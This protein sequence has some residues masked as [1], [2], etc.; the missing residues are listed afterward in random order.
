MLSDPG[1]ASA[2][3]PIQGSDVVFPVDNPVDPRDELLSGLNHMAHALA[4]Y[5][6]RSKLPATAQDSL[7]GGGRLPGQDS[8]LQGVKGGF[9]FYTGVQ[10]PPPPG[11]AWRNVHETG[12]ASIPPTTWPY[13]DQ[14]DSGYNE[15]PARRQNE[16]CAMADKAI[17]LSASKN[18][19]CYGPLQAD[20]S[21]DADE[22]HENQTA[23]SSEAESLR[24]SA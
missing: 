7:P 8:H 3:R 13:L 12:V 11:L 5:A 1:E 23:S 20:G 17:D 10:H 14:D 2:H 22:G 21:H 4:V 19:T 15:A 9:R 24:A 18:K 16:G 6:S